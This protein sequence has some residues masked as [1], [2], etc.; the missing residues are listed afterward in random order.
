MSSYDGG[1]PGGNGGGATYGAFSSRPPAGGMV[2]ETYVADNGIAGRY[3]WDGS[4]WVVYMHS[5]LGPLGEIAS[6]GWTAEGTG[7]NDVA[8]G[9][10]RRR[11]AAGGGT[12][13]VSGQFRAAPSTPFT[14]VSPLSASMN[15]GDQNNGAFIGFRSATGQIITVG[16]NDGNLTVIRWTSNSVFSATVKTVVLDVGDPSSIIAFKIKDTGVNI[17]FYVVDSTIGITG[18]LIYSE[19]RTAFLTGGPTSV[20]YWAYNQNTAVPYGVAIH[21][22]DES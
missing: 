7:T 1:G 20:G 16:F 5:G 17:E 11:L 10:F 19:S 6:T 12:A 13:N 15:T 4:A 21:A 14:I 8:D 2:G 9:I 3:V 22:W 18:E